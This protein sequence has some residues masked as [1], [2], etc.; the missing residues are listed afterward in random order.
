MRSG[1]LTQHADRVSVTGI[2]A[3][4][5]AMGAEVDVLGVALARHWRRQQPHDMH[6]GQAAIARELPYLVAVLHLLGEPPRQLGDDMPQ[7]VDLLLPSDL[8]LR[9][10]GVLQVLL[11]AQHAHHVG[12]IGTAR[13]PDVDR[14]H[15]AAAPGIVVEDRLYW[16]V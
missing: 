14:E 6:P 1:L 10:A 3:L 12:G 8:R 9:P 11:A 13:V 7:L 16:G 15:E 5:D 2:P 4:P